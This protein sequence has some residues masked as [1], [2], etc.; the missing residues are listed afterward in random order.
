MSL[1]R[2][3]IAIIAALLQTFVL[4]AQTSSGQQDSLVSLLSAESMQLIEERGISYR[5]VTGPARFF[6]NNTYLLCD[7]ALWNV[8]TDVIEAMG[9]VKILQ[10][11]TQL[12]SDKLTYFVK[13]DLAQFRG[14]LVQLEDKDRNVLRTRNLDYN[15]KDS[16]AVFRGGGAMR[17]SDGQII[18]SLSGTYDS[19]IKLFTFV[20]DVNM[21]TDSV[22]VKTSRIEY[23]AGTDIA[24]F[25]T[26]TDAWKDDAM[27]SSNAGWYDRGR[28]QFFFNRNVHGM[29]PDKE[30]WSDSLYFN[31]NTLD[32]EMLGNVQIDD[33][34]RNVTA[35]SGRAFYC[36][37]LSQVEMTRRPAVVGVMEG[38]GTRDTVWVSADTLRYRTIM[39]FRI[40]SLEFES[41]SKR[42]EDMGADAVT[43]YRRKAAED[44]AKA[45]E[46]AKKNNADYQTRQQAEQ[47]RKKAAQAKET[48]ASAKKDVAGDAPKVASDTT[49]AAA[50]VPEDDTSTADGVPE[51][52]SAGPVAQKDT[53]TAPAADSLSAAGRNTLAGA[54]RTLSLTDSLSAA[55]AGQAVALTDSIPGTVQDAA[56]RAAADSLAR[57]AADS[58]ARVAADSLA[59]AVADS[60][61]A[62]PKDS[63]K[64]GFLTAIK[65]VRLFKS[66]FQM[67]CDSLK[68]NDLDSLVRLHRNPFVWNDGNRQYSSDS[69]YVSFAGGHLSKAYLQSAA[70]IIVQEDSLCFDQIRSTEMLAYFGED[71]GLSR[72][73]ALG[74]ASAV[75][76]LKEDSTF[77]T[78]N[79]SQSRMLYAVLTD[80]E[81]QSVSYYD[82]AKNDAYPI[83]QMKQDDRVLKGFNWL[84]DNRPKGPRDITSYTKRPTQRKQYE[85]RPRAQFRQTDIYFPGYMEG[86]YREIEVSDSLKKVRDV[87]RKEQEALSRQIAQA[88]SLLAAND[89]ADSLE[90]GAGSLS[91]VDSL[92]LH[93]ADSLSAADALPAVSDSLS[94]VR[95]SLA[96]ADTVALSP[97]ERAKAE[98]EARRREKEAARAAKIAA[99]EAEWARL[100][101]LDAAKAARKAEAKA[102]KERARKLKIL[103]AEQKRLQK[104]QARLEAYRKK[105]EK[106][107]ARK[108]ARANK[109]AGRK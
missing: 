98:K 6:H 28:E 63:T 12:T 2:S 91:A 67:R 50:G 49:A 22:F 48:A 19:K 51:T 94:A 1:K 60:I 16:V 5:K 103:L 41:A 34:T 39:K 78:V 68:Y 88:D 79:K 74:D 23:D 65:D 18:E 105:Y 100:D 54:G 44:A 55:G 73:D 42:L 20:S 107:K 70:F 7:T 71:G 81:L 62:L 102:E 85:S 90:A 53:L 109:K 37:T 26:G 4:S 101:S 96:A 27:L 11:D 33:T 57:V 56:A 24:V 75:F 47:N 14:N 61:A 72:F 30:M 97:K 38:E 40:D 35:L 108:E 106:Q 10:N 76:Y 69:I 9:N 93:V 29:N 66:D 21:F 32:I 83:A 8:N 87:R 15:T 45:A 36:D 86:V 31:R 95:D 52:A 89:V 77:A 64:L 80:G 59:K 17:S 58:L 92:A 99:R 82:Q 84:P 46:E 43:A 104:E 25:G 13:D 3:L